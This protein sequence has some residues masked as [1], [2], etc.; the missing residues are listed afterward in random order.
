MKQKM[1]YS[2]FIKLIKA[3]GWVGVGMNA[4]LIN[5]PTRLAAPVPQIVPPGRDASRPCSLC[6]GEARFTTDR[7]GAAEHP[8]TA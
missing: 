3:F 4:K 1:I 5:S 6:G 8:R 7:A 2:S